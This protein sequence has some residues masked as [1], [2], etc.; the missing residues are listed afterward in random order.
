MSWLLEPGRGDAR[1]GWCPSKAPAI[2]NAVRFALD[3]VSD[4][5]V[6]EK[7]AQHFGEVRI[8]IWVI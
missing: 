2:A 6:T 7:R 4:L 5:A 8:S 1:A 3:P